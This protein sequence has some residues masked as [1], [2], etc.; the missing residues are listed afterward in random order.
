MPL[1]KIY[2]VFA[3]PGAFMSHAEDGGD[4]RE[5]EPGGLGI[6]DE[7]QPIHRLLAVVPVPVWG[8]LGFR[9]DSDVLVVTDGLGRNPDTTGELSDLHEFII[10]T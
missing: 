6:T 5:S 10:D 1:E 8:A 3:G 9:E 7:L 2:D 4:L